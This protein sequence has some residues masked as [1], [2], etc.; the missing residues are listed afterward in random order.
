MKKKLLAIL[1][2][3]VLCLS[4]V[5]VAAC[6]NDKP[7]PGPSGGTEI[8]TEAGKVTLYWKVVNSV[9]L[10]DITSYFLC[11][12]PNS[13]T[14]GNCDYELKQLGDT[15]TFYV[16]MDPTV[17]AGAEY[18]VLIG[19]N[20]KSP[21]D[22]AQQGPFWANEGYGSK[23]WAAGGPNSVVPEFT[24]DKVDCGTI[25]FD[26]CLG[27]PV[28][29]KNFDVKVSFVK[30]TLN[31]D[32]VVF[33]A[34][35][36]NSWNMVVS[37]EG[38]SRATKDTSAAN[39]ADL[40]VYKLNVPT[41]FAK[42]NAEYLV[43]VFPNGLGE[44]ITNEDGSEGDI[45]AYFNRANSGAIK[46]GV[47][48]AGS[49]GKIDITD[50]YTDDYCEVANTIS[51]GASA[52]GLDLSKAVENTNEAGEG[53]GNYYLNMDTILPSVDVILKITFTE[54][55]P[56][57][58]IVYLAGSGLEG[59]EWNENT[60]TFTPSDDRK[61]FT[62]SVKAA[63]GTTIEFKVVVGTTA[64]GGLDWSHEYNDGNGQNVKV[65]IQDAGEVNLY[66]SALTYSAE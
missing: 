25:E 58:L 10:T 55:L 66:E 61:T 9:K 39:S 48:A 44:K 13:W 40:D 2:A 60:L 23:T 47:G 17:A 36:F 8:P 52:R 33:I 51:Q 1:L 42:E 56:A 31:D 24:G 18:K 45:W 53:L 11:G 59:M 34:G 12:G 14:Q 62:I 63:I 27:E 57:D 4:I 41:M 32:S 54:A 22:K 26:G 16:F 28:P 38:S 3:L 65:T 21:V 49:N 7:G 64:E 30:G 5:A 19:Y 15:D 43:I 46:I 20:S 35:Q 29:V 6:D 37:G 50:L